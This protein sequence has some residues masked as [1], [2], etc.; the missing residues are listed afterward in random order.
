MSSWSCA[1]IFSRT[2]WSIEIVSAVPLQTK[3]TRCEDIFSESPRPSPRKSSIAAPSSVLRPLRCSPR[4]P[5]MRATRLSGYVPLRPPPRLEL[6]EQRVRSD[7]DHSPRPACTHLPAVKCSLNLTYPRSPGSPVVKSGTRKVSSNSPN[8]SSSASSGIGSIHTSQSPGDGS[9][10]GRLGMASSSMWIITVCCCSLS[11]RFCSLNSSFSCC[12]SRCLDLCLRPLD[13][14]RLRRS[15]AL[16]S[17]MWTP[18][19]SVVTGFPAIFWPRR[20]DHARFAS[21][22]F[23]NTTRASP[24]EDE[25]ADVSISTLTSLDLLTA[26]RKKATTSASAQRCGKPRIRSVLPTSRACMP[27][28]GPSLTAMLKTT[29]FSASTACLASSS[30]AN[31][32][33][34]FVPSSTSSGCTDSVPNTSSSVMICVI[35]WE[36]SS[37]TQCS[38]KPAISTYVPVARNLPGQSR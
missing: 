21:N 12:R 1:S 8:T 34:A 29:P 24:C 16:P 4:G 32:A 15:P 33:M 10:L 37:D 9:T 2:G 20:S 3:C 17:S 38:G 31:A 27:G 7:S 25:S 30:S 23:A 35:N 5:I 26:P 28:G 11:L 13:L 36:G 19:S 22:A 14:E 6:C 18:S